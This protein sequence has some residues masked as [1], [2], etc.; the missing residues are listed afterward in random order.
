MNLPKKLLIFVFE[1]VAIVT[2]V[3]LNFYFSLTSNLNK[4]EKRVT[5]GNLLASPPKVLAAAV[6]ATPAPTPIPTP[7]P[8]HLSKKTYSI[9]AI[10]DSMVETMGDSLEYLQPILKRKY[11]NTNFVLYN[12]GVGGE[13]V[14]RGLAMFDNEFSHLAKHYPP[15]PDVNPDILI[16]GSFAYNPFPPHNRDK[17]WSLLSDLIRRA[18]DSSGK[19]YV[20]AEIAPLERGFGRGPG[21]V[22]WPEDLAHTQALHIIEQLENAVGLGRTMG[23]DLVNVYSLSQLPG[24]KFGRPEYVDTNDGIHPSVAGQ[25]LTAQA[26]ASK[27]Q[28]R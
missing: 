18:E 25:I 9:A 2:L 20:L 5:F 6:E 15:L 4:I 26:I 24:S 28:L 19:V 13:N 16:V 23:V 11:P 22:N 1:I 3:E 21:G 8:P 12:Y 17:H 27:I 7:K 10:G 14:E